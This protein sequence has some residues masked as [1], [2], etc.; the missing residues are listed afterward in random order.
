MSLSPREKEVLSLIASGFTLHQIA[1]KLG[2]S[3]GCAEQYRSRAFGKL[4]AVSSPHAVALAFLSGL[5]LDILSY[6]DP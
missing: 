3:T 2:I 1:R 4:G 6:F 5:R